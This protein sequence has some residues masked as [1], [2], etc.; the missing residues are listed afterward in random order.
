MS[1]NSYV[2]KKE[3]TMNNKNLLKAI[4][5]IRSQIKTIA[6]DGNNPAFRSKYATLKGIM[7]VLQPLFDEHKLLFY[8]EF[9][10]VEEQPGV[11]SHLIWIGGEEPEAMSV[12]FPIREIVDSQKMG[13]AMTY[14]RRY[15]L[16]AIFNLTFDEDDDK[17]DSIEPVMKVAPKPIT[18]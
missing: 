4:F 12:F 17:G 9:G 2:N 8:S 11:I 16:G 13:A 3:N 18:F 10:Q 14:G 5:D 1:Y 7:D 15:N 6:Q